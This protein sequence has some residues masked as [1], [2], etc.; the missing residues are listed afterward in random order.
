[1]RHPKPSP[2]TSAR[3]C[4]D[5]S[6]CIPADAIRALRLD[7]KQPKFT[8][9]DDPWD[10]WDQALDAVLALAPIAELA[11]SGATP[12]NPSVEPYYLPMDCPVCGRHRMEWDGKILSCEKCFTSSVFD[13]FSTERYATPPVQ[14]VSAET[15]LTAIQDLNGAN[16]QP[17]DRNGRGWVR[18]S[19][20]EDIFDAAL[21]AQPTPPA[22]AA[23]P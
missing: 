23:E 1:M 6:E 16:W 21:R 2:P 20:V 8:E 15:L 12:R 22:P 3:P 17:D 5:H 9:L 7:E 10:G 13:G 4:H 11:D 19:A 18:L 14:P